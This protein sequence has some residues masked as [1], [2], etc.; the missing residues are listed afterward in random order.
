MRILSR[1]HRDYY[2]SVQGYG[3]DP[4]LVYART[5]F[6][7]QIEFNFTH[8]GGHYWNTVSLGGHDL[9]LNTI[10]VGFCG[11]CYPCVLIGEHKF[12]RLNEIDEFFRSQLRKDIYEKYYVNNEFSIKYHVAKRRWFIDLFTVAEQ[13]KNKYR[14]LFIKSRSPIFTV[15][16]AKSIIYNNRVLRT[17]K[18]NDNLRQHEFF[19]VFDAYRAYQE[20]AMFLSNLAVPLKPIPA[21]PD[22]IMVGAKGFDKYSFRKDKKNGT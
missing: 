10:V 13:G 9:S 16:M 18:W 4:S 21:I 20:I 11:T 17:L 8:I 7:E 1:N 14:E 2:D 6:E 15:D 3:F 12:Y 5:P 19:R 22:K